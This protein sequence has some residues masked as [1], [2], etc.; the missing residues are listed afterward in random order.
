MIYHECIAGSRAYGLE[1]EGSDIDVCRIADSWNTAGHDGEKHIIQV[2]REE[3]VDRAVLQRETPLYIQWWFPFEINTPGALSEYLTE[4]RESVVRASKKR[5]WELHIRTAHGL[6]EHPEHYYPR[7]PKRLAY[8]THY[9]DML[10]KYAAGESF[11]DV[12]RA[13]GDMREALIAMRK[14]ELPLKEAIAINADARVRA[15]A[16]ANWYDETADTGVLNGIQQDLK[17]LLGL[18]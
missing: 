16:C 4:N 1:I 18:R 5:V 13:S 11:A 6:S 17:E 14:N 2:P 9:Y 15:E 12:I 8:S 3:F 7:F 10:S